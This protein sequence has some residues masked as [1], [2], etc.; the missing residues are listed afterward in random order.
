MRKKELCEVC[1]K[2]IER[3]VPLSN[4]CSKHRN[5]I[6]KFLE[7]LDLIPTERFKRAFASMFLPGK[8][9]L[10]TNQ[11]SRKKKRKAVLAEEG[12]SERYC[13]KCE[14][15]APVGARYCPFCGRKLE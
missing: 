5:S 12:V 9:K 2:P 7:W 15:K 6:Y 14:E 8:Q 1:H 10:G 3:P 4:K 11:Y 13:Y